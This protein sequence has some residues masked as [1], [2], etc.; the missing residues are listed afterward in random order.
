ML[1]PKISILIGSNRAT[2][3][4]AL[5]FVNQCKI[6]LSLKEMTSTCI[7]TIAKKIN[8][9]NSAYNASRALQDVVRGGQRVRVYARYQ[10]ESKEESFMRLEFAGWV[11]NINP[12]VPMEI[13]CEDEMYVLKRHEVQP[14]VFKGGKV[15]DVVKYI[16][17]DIV[18]QGHA[19]HYVLDVLDSSLG[20][21]FSI[22]R[23]ENTAAK[24]LAKIEEV[25]G[26]KSNFRFREVDGQVQNIL[27]VG[28]QYM[29]TQGG[30]P[31]RYQLNRNVI[32]NSLSYTRA[33]DKQIRVRVTS[34]QADGK[35]LTAAFRGDNEGDTKELQIPGLN[36]A[37]V[38][39]YARRLYNESKVD[40]FEGSITTF[41]IPVITPGMLA[42]IQAPDFEINETT[43]YVD[44]VET[45]IGVDG[46]RRE[47]VLGPRLSQNNQLTLIAQ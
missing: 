22:T 26:L 47:I 5:N 27:V 15:S 4:L 30:A 8:I 37:Q 10:Q 6:S 35:S 33:A 32:S 16:T 44:E 3:L 43:N 42:N 23:E 28:T 40:S 2:G 17:Q 18:V 31:V 34:R 25:Y 41:G 14:R 7:I 12:A 39:E 38:E 20:G 13:E 24:V 21:V 9:K 45:T 46:Y 19:G 29:S 36:Q 1:N 11:R